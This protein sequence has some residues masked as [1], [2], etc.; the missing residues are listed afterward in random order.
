MVAEE[1]SDNSDQTSKI[2]IVDVHDDGIETIESVN[3]ILERNITE[4]VII[5]ETIETTDKAEPIEEVL[6]VFKCK[7]CDFA[8]ARKTGLRN[9]KKQ[10]H[11]WCFLCFSSFTCQEKLKDHFYQVHSEDR[12]LVTG[13]AP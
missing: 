9:H 3:D 5:E 2:I 6:L 7:L 12:D 10:I 1:E 4:I 8:S 11:N 13:K